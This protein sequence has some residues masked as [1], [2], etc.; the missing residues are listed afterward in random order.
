MYYFDYSG[1]KVSLL[2]MGCMRLPSDSEGNVDTEEA[3]NT[4]REGID[5]G[6]TYLDTAYM[7]HGGYSERILG[8]ALKDGY[9][10][11]VLVADKMPPWF[12]KK[13]EDLEVIFN[14]QLERLDI[15]TIDIYL[16]HDIHG[17]T[18]ELVKEYGVLEFMEQKR[19]EGK[20]RYIG[21]SF[22]DDYDLFEEVINA[23]PWDVCQIQYNYVDVDFQAGRRGLEL[24][25]SK[26][27]PVIIME[28]M[29]GGKLAGG[30]PADI[31]PLWERMSAS[32]PPVDWGF[33]WVANQP[34]ILTILS[35]MSSREQLRYNMN[36]F[37]SLAPGCLSEAD[38]LVLEDISSKFREL[39]E[40]D[41]T[42]CKYCMPCPLEINIPKIIDLYNQL[43][44][45][46]NKEPI[47]DGYN[48]VAPHFASTCVACKK[49]ESICPQK[50]PVSEIMKKASLA[51]DGKEI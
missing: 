34:G 19:A 31:D 45:F 28:P 46:E 13:K 15:D 16:I 9:R 3:I 8:Q 35:G 23:Y 36:L 6:I 11:K 25:R 41:C 20:I 18:W 42:A 29:K 33:A 38:N 27:I 44:L 10:E 37:D 26:G 17:S 12:A 5:G 50:L 39:T 48:W 32:R 49:C 1:E 47:Y 51:F 40:Y 4:I 30:L 2:G 43:A 24:A 21:F 7:Y 22:H 14:K